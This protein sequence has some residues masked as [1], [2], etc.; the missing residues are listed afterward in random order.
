MKVQPTPIHDCF[1]LI[2]KVFEDERGYFFEKFNKRVFEKLTG[3]S[4]E[5]V[6]DNESLSTYGVIRGLHAQ[7]A[8]AAQAKLV[9]V[10]RGK[11]LDV[12]VDIRPGSETYGQS[13]SIELSEKNK[14]LLFVPKG[15]LHGFAVLSQE[16]VFVYKCDEFYNAKMEIGV[17]F[18]DPDLKIDW[19]IPLED[20]IISKKDQHLPLLKDLKL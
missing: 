11:V 19:Q 8:D 16:A 9:S 4:V 2:P 18:D 5:F 17:K 10:S 14:K 15:L 12:V 7:K 1:V 20:R 3:L 6:Q 13:F